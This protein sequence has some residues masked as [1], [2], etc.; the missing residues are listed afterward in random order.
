[1]ELQPQEPYP[2]GINSCSWMSDWSKCA[3]KTIS[4]DSLKLN[5]VML[6]VEVLYQLQ[7]Q[8][9]TTPKVRVLRH[10]KQY[11]EFLKMT[12]PEINA[13][14]LWHFQ[15]YPKLNVFIKVALLGHCLYAS[16][17]VS[18]IH[19]VTWFQVTPPSNRPPP[20][21]FFLAPVLCRK[22]IEMHV[23]THVYRHLHIYLHDTKHVLTL[24]VETL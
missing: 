8:P 17:D 1:M 5:M 20:L 10:T 15:M 19:T 6:D 23:Y 3:H 18:T 22:W 16:I 9:N 24:E 21:L 7:T 11:L 4:K 13:C 14:F 2:W 12:I